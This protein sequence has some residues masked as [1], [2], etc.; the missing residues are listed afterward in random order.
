MTT[1]LVAEERHGKSSATAEDLRADRAYQVEVDG[2]TEAQWSEG[3]DRFA[4]ANLYQS[5]SYGAARWKAENL[6]HLILKRDGKVVAMAQLRIVQPGNLRLGVAYLRW[7]PMCQLQ[8]QELD[9]EIVR[10]MAAA[11]REEYASK[12]GLYLEILPNAFSGSQRGG[13]FQSAFA[14]FDSGPGISDQNYRTL[15]LDLSPSLDELRKKLDKKWRNQLNA[16]ERNG[17]AVVESNDADGYRRFCVLYTQMWERKKFDTKVSIEEF[18]RIQELLSETQRM[19]VLICEH[20]GTPVA[21]VV[22]SAIG[23]SAIY[24]LGATNDEGMKVKASYLLQWTIIRL[25]KERNIRFY[26]LG[27]I[28]PEAN[29]GVYHF[30]SGLSGADLSHI[31]SRSAC[32][33]PVSAALVKTGQVLR[34]GLHGLQQRLARPRLA[35]ATR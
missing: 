13:M 2:V 6:S 14:Q 10:S 20:A 21:G 7:G 4:D 32:D 9:P 3:M 15:V 1:A 34:G 25:L 8:G 30:K 33:N 5:W 18:Q 29:P 28:D 12:R 31:S 23:D 16:A 19:K 17:L 27:G 22:C 26:D 35:E 24:L 11:L